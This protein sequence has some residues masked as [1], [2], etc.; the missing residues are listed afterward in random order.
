MG[1][2]A[3]EVVDNSQATTF[4]GNLAARQRDARAISP[5]SSRGCIVMKRIAV[6]AFVLAFVG[7]VS[8]L[9]AADDP[10]GTW[11]LEANFGGKTRV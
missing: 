10:T 8:P 11:K 6:A 4:L 5:S 2:E 3:A 7:L 9:R 1:R